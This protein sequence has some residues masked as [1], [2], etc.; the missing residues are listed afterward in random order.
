[1]ITDA[2]VARVVLEGSRAVGVEVHHH[3]A[4]QVVRAERE[5]ILSAGAYNSPKLLMLSGVGRAAEL[6]ALGIGPRMDL[7]VGE[8]LQDHPSVLLTYFTEVPTLFRSG[9]AKDLQLFQE[10]GRGPLT[11]N[12]GEGGGFFRTDSSL[13]LPDVMFHVGP[14]MVHGEFLSPPLGDAYTLAPQVLKPTS[15]GQV[16]LRNG[17]PDA[18]PRILNRLLTTEE[19][20]RSLIRGVQHMMEVVDRPALAEVTVRPHLAPASRRAADVWDFIQHHAMAFFHPTSTCGIGRVVDPQLRVLGVEHLRVVD[21]SVMPTIIRGN[22][23]APVIA[24]AE[25]AAD[26]IVNA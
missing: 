14:A 23:N 5:V 18:K 11:S 7:P 13:E 1:V 22:T 16:K 26:M 19:D 4:S 9:T 10:S 25:K 12:I 24:I 15:R 8:D 6:A 21:A 17:R 3:G 2:T 20:R